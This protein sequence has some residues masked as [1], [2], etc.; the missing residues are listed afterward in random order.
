MTATLP[1]SDVTVDDREL[2]ERARAGD[3]SAFSELYERHVTSVTNVARSRVGHEDADDV[4][5]D[6]FV[7]AW[8][9]IEQ[10][11]DGAAF[12][13]WVRAIAVRV[14]V[15]VH[16][17]GS[18]TVLSDE[19]ADGA[20]LGL[21][22]DELL[23]RHEDAQ[24]LHSRLADLSVR[25][26][27]ALWLRDGLEAPIPE[28]A[29]RLDLTEGSTRVMLSR[30]RKRLRAAYVALVT[31]VLGLRGLRQLGSRAPVMV[32]ASALVAVPLLLGPGLGDDVADPSP[33]TE[34]SPRA[35][36]RVSVPS[37]SSSGE[38]AEAPTAAR[39]TDGTVPAAPVPS[40]TARTSESSP[41]VT[42]V[43]D[44]PVAIEQ[45]PAPE[46]EQA[47]SI[48]GED[49]QGEVVGADVFAGTVSEVVSG[50][51]GPDDEED[52]DES[53]PGESASESDE[54]A[55]GS[56]DGE[57]RRERCVLLCDDD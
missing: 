17:R 47:I 28:V 8:E 45:R 31:G 39:S 35:T 20:A 12:G 56:S 49:G 7:K 43:V 38:P 50:V 21:A 14:S 46:G 48:E 27:Q 23:V 4:V 44:G 15:D 52:E 25:D 53:D 26:R 22:A 16:R 51:T 19:L 6:A 29:D 34:T 1:A 9:R 32:A 57:P 42:P 3:R 18:R 13:G 5:Q 2:V 55:G 40:P 36:R 24:E 41:T 10:L 54:D 37:P 30:A 11:R 33:R